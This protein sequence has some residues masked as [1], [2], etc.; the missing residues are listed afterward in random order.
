MN[1]KNKLLNN[2]TELGKKLQAAANLV[3]QVEV[4][5]RSAQREIIESGGFEKESAVEDLLEMETI[6]SKL[7]AAAELIRQSY[8]IK[9]YDLID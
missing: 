4:A 6:S 2:T 7:N 1:V 5:L 3:V 9:D 8:H